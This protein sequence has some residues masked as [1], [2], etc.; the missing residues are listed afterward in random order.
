MFDLTPFRR[1]GNMFPFIDEIEKNF[2]QNLG[3][4]FSAFKT[5]IVDKGDSFMLEAELPGF[6]RENI[7]IH[8]DDNRLTISAEHNV[9]EEESKDNFILPFTTADSYSVVKTF[10]VS[11]A[12][13]DSSFAIS[14]NS[15][16]VQFS[17]ILTSPTKTTLTFGFLIKVF[18]FLPSL[19]EWKYK[20]SPSLTIERG[21][22]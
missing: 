4:R 15:S 5:D 16:L 13:L 1:R 20:L 2:M 18:T 22:P 3:E 19:A 9:S 11:N 8:V 14:S 7:N 6:S 21:T 10:L 17:G 12:A